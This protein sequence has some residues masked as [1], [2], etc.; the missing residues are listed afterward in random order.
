MQ[1]TI[2][3]FVGP[4]M[5]ICGRIIQRCAVCG[6]K[7][8]DSEGVMM[9][10]GPDEPTRHFYTWP[11]GRVVRVTL[12]NPTSTVVLFADDERLPHDACI[13]GMDA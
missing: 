1:H 9:P 8:C 4:R 3:H 2:T 7:L 6:A 10:T 12:G 11:E 13:R 5:D